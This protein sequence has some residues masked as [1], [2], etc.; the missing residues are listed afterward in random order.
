MFLSE[1]TNYISSKAGYEMYY[2]QPIEADAQWFAGQQQKGGIIIV[3]PS[4]KNAVIV[5]MIC[6]VVVIC[7]FSILSNELHF[8][9]SNNSELSTQQPTI[10]EKQLQEP[11]SSDERAIY[12]QNI[13]IICEINGVSTQTAQI[14]ANACFEYGREGIMDSTKILS[15]NRQLIQYSPTLQCSFIHLQMEDNES[16][17]FRVVN[18]FLDQVWHD[19]V[20]NGTLIY[21][22]IE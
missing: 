4:K 15:A 2:S 18:N 9:E 8:S 5:L 20:G 22:V 12:D 16:Y 19:C 1:Q 6:V 10:A 13:N 3:A 11:M 21:G 7:V 17:W 14:I